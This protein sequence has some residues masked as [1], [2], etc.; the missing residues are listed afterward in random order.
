MNDF[1]R[2]FSDLLHDESAQDLIEYALVA[3]VIGLGAAA[4]MRTFTT[5]VADALSTIGSR[6]TNSV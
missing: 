2:L 4:A 6:L 3:A 1:K 5:T